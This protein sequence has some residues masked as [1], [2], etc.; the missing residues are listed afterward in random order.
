MSPI[1]PQVSER[2]GRIRAGTRLAVRE[3]TNEELGHH[4]KELMNLD[5]KPWER[6]VHPS[7]WIV[8]LADHPEQMLFDWFSP[9]GSYTKELAVK[10]AERYCQAR[11]AI[12]VDIAAAVSA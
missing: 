6:G 7:R 1:I 12:L 9:V 8:C 2:M 5:D 10:E 3:M 11:G 4:V